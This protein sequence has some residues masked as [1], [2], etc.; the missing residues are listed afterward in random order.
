MLTEHGE[1]WGDDVQI[2]GLSIDKDAPTVVNHVNNKGWTSVKHYH[3]AKSNASEV[4][5]VNGVPHV[6]ILDKEG[7]IVFKGHPANRKDLVKDFNDLLEGKS[8]EG[9]E[10]PGE[11]AEGDDATPDSAAGVTADDIQKVMEQMDKFRD[12]GKEL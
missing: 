10:K 5:K 1:K 3:R 11:A 8:L 9:V 12:I 2:I 4:Y 6:M 7:T